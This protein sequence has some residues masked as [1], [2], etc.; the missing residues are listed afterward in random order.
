LE[1]ENYIYIRVQRNEGK[2]LRKND[3]KSSNLCGLTP[4]LSN[5]AT[6]SE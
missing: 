3:V 2:R 5:P 1:G 4:I 6:L